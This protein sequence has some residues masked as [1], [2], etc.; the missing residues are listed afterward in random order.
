MVTQPDIVTAD[1]LTDAIYVALLEDPGYMDLPVVQTTTL[2]E[3]GAQVIASSEPVDRS[4]IELVAF[5]E[6]NV[7]LVTSARFT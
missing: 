4:P 5:A 7:V 2:G 1:Q 6:G 3:E